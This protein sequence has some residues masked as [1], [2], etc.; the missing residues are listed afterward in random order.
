MKK[1]ILK[2]AGI[3]LL[4]CAVSAAILAGCG[5]IGSSS[6]SSSGNSSSS[7]SSSAGK[8]RSGKTL[9]VYYSASGNTEKLAKE[10]AKTADADIFEVMPKKPY[11][12]DDLDWTNDDSRISKEHEDSSLQNVPLKSTKVPKWSSYK[13][14]FI[15][16]PIWWG[17]AAWP[18]NGFVKANSFKGKTVI[19]FCSSFSSG[20]GSSATDLEKLTNT[21]NWEGGHRF[22]SGASSSSVD[23]WVKSLGY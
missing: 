6:S 23:N 16:Y 2:K 17:E 1:S 7:S 10:I 4:T 9:V 14:V 3:L 15:G 18:I 21:G 20:I 11:T 5:F 12:D 22:S 8:S 13:T 19:P